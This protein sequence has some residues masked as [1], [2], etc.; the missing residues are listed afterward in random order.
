MLLFKERFSSKWLKLASFGFFLSIIWLIFDLCLLRWMIL[1]LHIRC[2][3]LAFSLGGGFWAERGGTWRIVF[4]SCRFLRKEME[5]FGR[6]NPPVLV[7]Y[8]FFP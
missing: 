8:P 3:S 7:Y 1:S 4:A 6:R 2:I 5:K